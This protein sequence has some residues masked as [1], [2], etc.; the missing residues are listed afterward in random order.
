MR[1]VWIFN[2]YA[3]P[4]DRQA[5]RSF[6]LGRELV[7]RGHAVTIFS[8]SFSHYRFH[9]EKLGA[10]G[11]WIA[12]QIEG[13]KFIWLR[14][15]P[16]TR[17]DWR[18][19]LNMISYSVRASLIGLRQHDRPDVIIGVTVHPLAALAA[20]LVARAKGARFFFEVTDLWPRTLVEFGMLPAGHP[21]VR[22]LGW[23]ER[24]LFRRAER[25]IS[26]LPHIDEYLHELGVDA[27]KVVWIPNG[28]DLRR[29]EV[30]RGYDGAA[31]DP[32]T[33]MYVGGLVQANALDVVL[34]AAHIL[35]ERGV[36]HVRFVFVGGGQ[37]QPRLR[38]RVRALGLQNVDFRG[39][40]AK[41]E[42]PRVMLGADAFVFS[43]RHLSLYQYGISLNKMCDYLAA[44]RPV[45]FA[46][47][48]SY[49]PIRT[50]GAGFTVPPENPHA[51][52]DAIVTLRAL[53]ASERARMGANGIAYVREYH[54]IHHLAA[55]LEALL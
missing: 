19:L 12:E 16:Y 47:S 22:A 43:L 29:Y 6:D 11:T 9:E 25:V 10:G 2:H 23:L 28:V 38:E 36:N 40:V 53:P 39:V 26:L 35:Q 55:R 50:A 4:P 41:D 49:D 1:K 52:A 15:F 30:L 34:D 18:R 46:G 14:T 54:D 8:S 17:N 21:A 37:E 3:E 32:F 31:R 45:L 48:S 7:H 13:V 27:E 33:V 5:T 44:G 20:Y 24:E 42:L 51:L